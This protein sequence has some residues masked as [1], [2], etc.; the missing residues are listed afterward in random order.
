MRIEYLLFNL[1]ILIG[2][3]MLS[4]DRRVRYVTKWPHALLASVTS[5]VPFIIW[6]IT[7]NGRHWWFNEKYI[8]GL[9]LMGLPLEEW[10]FFITVPFACLFV[11]EIFYL[12]QPRRTVYGAEKIA[13]IL[14]LLAPIGIGVFATGKEYTGLVLIALAAVVFLDHVLKTRLLTDNRFLILTGVVVGLTVIFNTYLTARPIVLYNPIY[15]L[16]LRVIT[17]P[18]EDFFYGFSHIFLGVIIYHKIRGN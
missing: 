11:W 16:N 8:L 12:L 17:I 18:V 15:Q 7:V 4:F 9:R 1:I 10:F 6:D 13:I 3:V 2:P 14:L 5:L